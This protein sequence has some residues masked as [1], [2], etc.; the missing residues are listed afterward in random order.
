MSVII[1]VETVD[2]T[3]GH[4]F[5]GISKKNIVIPFIQG[6]SEISEKPSFKTYFQH[7]ISVVNDNTVKEY[8]LILADYQQT[9]ED[10]KEVPEAL[11][12]MMLSEKKVLF[13]AVKVLI[14]KKEEIFYFIS[15]VNAQNFVD[16]LKQELEDFYTNYTDYVKIL[17]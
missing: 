13:P 3:N 7:A 14:D 15:E 1:N 17:K 5:K 4:N 10:L 16:T 12:E 6:F 2:L 9:K 8:N 11:Q